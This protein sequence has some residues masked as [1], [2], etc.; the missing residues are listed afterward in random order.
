MPD[1]YTLAQREY[2]YNPSTND[3]CIYNEY[4]EDDII[5]ECAPRLI[6]PDA[7]SNCTYI[8]EL[9]NYICLSLQEFDGGYN[10]G[11]KAPLNPKD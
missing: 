11:F 1:K 7:D 2:K 5:Y 3:Y 8:S 10:C 9:S 6:S 4:L